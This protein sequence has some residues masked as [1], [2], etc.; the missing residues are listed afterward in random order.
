MAPVRIIREDRAPRFAPL[1][2]HHPIVG[3]RRTQIPDPRFE[4]LLDQ[5]KVIAA[6]LKV[7][8]AGGQEVAIQDALGN[9]AGI[10]PLG[11]DGRM[12]GLEGAP[13][14]AEFILEMPVRRGGPRG[15]G[16]LLDVVD[17]LKQSS[18]RVCQEGAVVDA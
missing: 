11:D 1:R 8:G 10:E 7:H 4:G 9:G 18:R 16:G 5:G 12:R 15:V 17:S 14:L 6:A 13:E 3:P 2:G